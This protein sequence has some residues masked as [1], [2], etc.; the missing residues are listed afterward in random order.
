MP[1]RLTIVIERGEGTP[2]D[3]CGNCRHENNFGT[4]C[5]VFWPLVRKEPDRRRLECQAA[6][7]E[8]ARTEEE[9]K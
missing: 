8:A 7:R 1:D 2:E 9:R 4:T 3:R 5:A 6:Q